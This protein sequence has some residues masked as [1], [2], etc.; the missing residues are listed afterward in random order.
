LPS[1]ANQEIPQS[2]PQGLSATQK[3]FSS[4]GIRLLSESLVDLG[5]SQL[6]VFSEQIIA[7]K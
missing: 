4:F 6:K 3:D 2:H 5:G 7:E 1:S